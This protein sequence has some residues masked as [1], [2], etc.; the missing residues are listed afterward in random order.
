MIFPFFLFS[1]LFWHGPE[2]GIAEP[3]AD[4]GLGRVQQDLFV[5]TPSKVVPARP[6]NQKKKT[7][8]EETS[9]EIDRGGEMSNPMAGNWIPLSSPHT[10]LA[11]NTSNSDD[12]K[13]GMIFCLKE[14]NG[15]L[16]ATTSFHSL[17]AALSLRAQGAP[18]WRPR[19]RR[20]T[21]RCTTRCMRRELPWNRFE[22]CRWPLDLWGE[23]SNQRPA[24][25]AESSGRKAG[26]CE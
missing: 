18:P 7:I 14:K 13:P 19:R 21:C 20:W 22:I 16:G 12:D 25:T 8:T 11:S 23:A 15:R 5:H 2:A 6:P 17:C 10:A 4:H 9:D 1:F 3:G 26:E 24:K